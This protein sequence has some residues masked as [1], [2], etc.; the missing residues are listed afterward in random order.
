MPPNPRDTALYGMEGDS[1]T[2]TCIDTYTGGGPWLCTTGGFVQG[3]ATV[4]ALPGRLR[5]LTVLHSDSSLCGVF[6]W[7]RRALNSQKR[8]VSARAVRGGRGPRPGEEDRDLH[9]EL[10][11]FP[12][13]YY[14]ANIPYL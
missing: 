13:S 4:R 11:A 9:G 1:V 5:A 12:L 3:P 14:M 10:G 8:R 6:V 7:A 2:V